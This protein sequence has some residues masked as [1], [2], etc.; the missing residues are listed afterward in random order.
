MQSHFAHACFIGPTFAS[1]TGPSD[2]I[3]TPVKQHVRAAQYVLTGVATTNLDAVTSEGKEYR[4]LLR[5]L[6]HQDSLSHC[7]TAQFT[8][9]NVFKGKLHAAEI[10]EVVSAQSEAPKF[11]LGKHYVL[12]LR[13][14][15]QRFVV[16]PCSYSSEL[17]DDHAS[18]KLLKDIRAAL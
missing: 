17:T 3:M 6:T 10:I 12:F 13:R 14:E 15:G 16:Y 1:A 2:C 18:A 5:N 7:I 11:E 8:I 4:W 9:S